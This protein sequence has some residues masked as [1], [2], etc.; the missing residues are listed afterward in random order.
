MKI[1][2]LD[3]R[4]RGHK[5]FTHRIQLIKNTSA[6][7]AKYETWLKANWGEIPNY[8]KYDYH[9]SKTVYQNDRWGLNH[10]RCSGYT[11]PHIYF[12]SEKDL[13]WFLMAQ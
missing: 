6:T 5:N 4:H 2:K 12:K 8:W 10:H 11:A 7:W 9:S 1:V 13:T 3:R